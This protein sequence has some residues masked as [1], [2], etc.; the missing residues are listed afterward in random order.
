MKYLSLIMLSFLWVFSATAQNTVAA[1]P[2]KKS[3]APPDYDSLYKG[4]HYPAYDLTTLDGKRL[5]NEVCRDKVTFISFWFEGC[6][7]C[8]EEFEEVNALYDSLKNDPQC[9]FVALTFDDTTGL[10]A[11]VTKHSLRFPIATT[12]QEEFRKLSYGMA[13]PSMVMLSRNGDI[14]FIGIRSLTKQETT[15]R[16]VISVAGALAKIRLLEKN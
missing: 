14:G 4:K 7:G 11:F 3:W 16:Y 1:A 8:R 12:S 5:T 13:C 10:K 9:N 2:E 6:S 15:G